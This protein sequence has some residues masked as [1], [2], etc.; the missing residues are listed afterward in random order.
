MRQL[1][2]RLL[3]LVLSASAAAAPPG[4][5]EVSS[6]A[7]LVGALVSNGTTK[8]YVPSDVS[9]PLN[10]AEISSAAQ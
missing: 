1:P 4:Y 3:L 8:L 2:T 10:G 7:A 5:V 6:R 9:I